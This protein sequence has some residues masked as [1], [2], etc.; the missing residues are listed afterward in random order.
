MVTLKSQGKARPLMKTW[1]SLVLIATSSMSRLA[2]ASQADETTIT[3]TAKTQGPT[4][5]INQLTLVASDT[6][7]LQSIQFTITPKAGSVTRP[8]SGTYGTDY[9]T[10]RGYILPGTNTI[11]LPV[12]GLYANYTN[13]VSL[14]YNFFDGSSKSD[15]T[16]ITAPVYD[17]PCQYNDPKVLQARTKSTD[18]SY[19]F[20]LVRE[21]CSGSSPTVLDSDS[22]VRWV[23]PAGIF[24][25][26]SAFFDNAFYQASGRSLNR[27]DLDGT[28]T[29]LHDYS[30]Y[31]VT[32]LHHNIDRGKVGLILDA[33]TS[34][35]F[36]STNLEVDAAGNVLKVWSLA[37]IISAAMTAGGDDPGEFVYPAPADW[38]HNNSVVYNRADDS[39]IIS[40]R[41][42]FVICIDYET[43]AIKWILGDPTKQWYQFPSLRQY[44]LTLADGSNAPIGQHT[45]SISYDQ[46][47]LLFDNGF[48]SWLHD[49][50]G[51]TRNYSSPRKYQLDLIAK[52]ATEVWNFPNG[53]STYSSICSGIYEDAPNNYLVDYAFVYDAEDG[54]R[55]GQI[56]GLDGS[57]ATV[58]HYQYTNVVSFCDVAYNSIPL[59][60]ENTKF[61][62]VGPQA[63]N[64]STRGN[65]GSGE[66]SLIGG[67]IITGPT[68]KELIVRALGP[69]LGDSD[70]SLTDTVADP[71]LSLYDSSG[72]LIV[73]NDNWQSDPQ[74]AQIAA[75]HLDPAYAEEAA[76][77]QFLA[78][79]AYTFVVNDK[80]KGAGLG[81][82]EAYDLTPS[83][84]SELANLSTRGLVGTDDDV[85][86]SGVIVGDLD[87]AT[88]CIRALGPSLTALSNPLPNPALAVYDANGTVLGGNNDWIEDPNAAEIETVGLAPHNPVEA[89]TLLHL[90]AGA[91]TAI[92]TG[93]DGISGSGLVEFYNLD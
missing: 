87:S 11:Y 24:N 18:L 9:L 47:L 30:D 14:T 81:L 17:D 50:P 38:F 54:T 68:A 89:A 90:P 84:G 21:R 64:L 10:D 8:L 4:P 3:I 79:G 15:S 86:I 78:P 41:E 19:D 66:D 59:H 1:L 53:F 63:L 29:F 93:V 37:D 32:Y 27:I 39:L 91:Y 58:F 67:F 61:P 55:N 43:S 12:Y 22:A 7:V 28:F 57:G 85:L 35:Y 34:S 6:S 49:P 75:K 77:L 71:F 25:I 23:G 80:N 72:N 56:L 60:L 46:D 92:V 13:T 5:F 74:A 45:V 69:S 73:A 62:P 16:T 42:N 26:T 65:V 82:V 76:T 51:A 33:D 48:N 44:A 2:F 20:I 31:D 36:E 88:V 70:P 40:S 83:S 52:T